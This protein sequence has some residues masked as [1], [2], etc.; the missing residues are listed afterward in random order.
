MKRNLLITMTILLFSL[1]NVMASEGICEKT[2]EICKGTYDPNNKYKVNCAISSKCP[3]R[4]S[5][6][7]VQKY[8]TKN[9]TYC[10]EFKKR[11]DQTVR[12]MYVFQFKDMK[13]CYNSKYVWNKIDVCVNKF[14]CMTTNH[15]QKLHGYAKIA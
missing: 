5:Y 14:N 1:A 15:I 8:C 3:N 13:A 11:L 10:H 2:E 4:M 12:R 6:T 9:R 7:C